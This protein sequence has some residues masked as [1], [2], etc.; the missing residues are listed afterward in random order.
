MHSAAPIARISLADYLAMEQASPDRHEWLD[1]VVYAMAGGT[2][3]HSQLAA[4]VIRL[5]GN[6]LLDRGCAVFTSDLRVRVRETGLD[7]YPDV[8][9]VCGP[10]ERDV[11]DAQAV[12]NPTLIV[13]VLSATTE[14]YDRGEKFAHYRRMHTL[15]EYVLVSQDEPRIECFRRDE[16]GRWVLFEAVAG[17][18]LGLTSLGGELVVNEVY[19]GVSLTPS[20][21]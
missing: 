19:R 10:V 6:L 17:E 12:T 20:A 16:L 1:G 18:R 2:P 14:A 8:T 7:T 5:L 9:V 15:K 13:E 4:G 21:G 11:A 3:E